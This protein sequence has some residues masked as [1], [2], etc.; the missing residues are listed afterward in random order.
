MEETFSPAGKLSLQKYLK[1][2][3]YKSPIGTSIIP[4][5]DNIHN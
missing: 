1:L 2:P 3:N 5:G 4:I